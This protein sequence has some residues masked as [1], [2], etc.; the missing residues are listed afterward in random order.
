M[1]GKHQGWVDLDPNDTVP[2]EK[3]TFSFFTRQSPAPAVTTIAEIEAETQ[4]ETDNKAQETQ[5]EEEDE[6]AEEDEAEEDEAEEDEAEE[7]EEDEAEEDE[8]EEDEAEEDEAEDDASLEYSSSEDEQNLDATSSSEDLM[9]N[10]KR[11]RTK[12]ARL[13]KQ[14]IEL[15]TYHTTNQGWISY[16]RHIST[17]NHNLHWTDI[18]VSV[19]MIHLFRSVITEISV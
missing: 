1:F 14:I 7:A 11:L 13:K 8:A 4:T 18:L 15:E 16:L 12:N 9:A 5:T 17:Y 2:P 6:T 10:L 3:P 19:A